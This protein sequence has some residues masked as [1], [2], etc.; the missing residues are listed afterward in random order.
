MS[1]PVRR[2]RAV[3]LLTLA[4][5]GGCCCIPGPVFEPAPKELVGKY[6]GELRVST[7]SKDEYAP[8]GE[9]T[10][11]LK[12]DG[13][14]VVQNLYW[15]GHRFFSGEGTWKVEADSSGGW[16][17][18]MLFKGEKGDALAGLGISGHG[19]PYTLVDEFV[20]PDYPNDVFAYSLQQ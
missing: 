1:I 11:E 6:A 5:L 3:G 7:V 17:V 18:A 9:Q 2:F 4:F 15:G 13:T 14:C 19:R 12:E 10:V 16:N 20:S 8:P